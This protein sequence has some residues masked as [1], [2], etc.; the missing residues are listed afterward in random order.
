MGIFHG[1]FPQV[2]EEHFK[3]LAQSVTK[4]ST[5]VCC[6]TTFR[7][8]I[9]RWFWGIGYSTLKSLK[10]EELFKMFKCDICESTFTRERNMRR[11]KK[12]VHEKST[13]VCC[14]KCNKTFTRADNLKAHL[15]VCGKY[16][17][18]K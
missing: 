17:F 10:K 3:I 13:G 2:L 16:F 1:D 12:N 5:E 18:S 15:K 6:T 7:K 14:N 8:Y 9:S 11:H 4:N